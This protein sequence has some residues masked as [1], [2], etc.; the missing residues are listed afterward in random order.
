MLAFTA[1]LLALAQTPDTSAYLDPQARGL[2][3]RAR[4]A[5]DSLET[6]ILAYTAVVKQRIGLALRTPL[7]DRMLFRS[8]TAARV[9]WSRDE[10]AV[11][12][13]LGA[14]EF[15]PGSDFSDFNPAQV[16]F[17]DLFDPTMDRLYFGLRPM[18]QLVGSGDN[19]MWI[20]HPLVEGAEAKYRYQTG[21]TI[22]M[23]FPDGRQVRVVELR[24][25]PRRNATRLVAG[26]IWIEP[27]TGS[28]VKAAYRLP[29]TFDLERDTEVFSARDRE[30]M[31]N[32][33]GIFKPLQVDVTMISVEY[34]YWRL[35]HWLPRSLRMEGSARAGIA[36]APVEIEI[37]YDMQEV[38]EPGDSVTPAADVLRAWRMDTD[39]L[40]Q[41]RRN[42]K[43]IH[44]LVPKDAEQ[45]TNSRDL[46]PPIWESAPDFITEKELRKMY[47]GLARLPL[48][49]AL[50][51]DVTVRWGPQAQ[52][53]LRY[54]RVEAL[55]VGARVEA[56]RTAGTFWSTA[57]LGLADFAPNLEVGA[58]RET[59]WRTLSVTASHGLTA[60]DARALQLGSSVAA[61][62]LGR[63]EGDYYRTTGV[64][65]SVSPPTAQPQWYQ[66]TLFA[67]R[68]RSAARETD[69]SLPH[70]FDR[71]L[72]FRPNLQAD[73]A[74]LAGAEL[75]LRKWWGS[76][77]RQW[78]AGVE[79][80]LEGAD[81]D[82]RFARAALTARTA[83]PIADRWRGALE[84]AGGS[85]EGEVPAQ[86]QFFLGGAHTL[87][88]YGG[89]AAVGT[90]F[91][92][93]RTELAYT[94]SSAGLSLFSD[95]GWA[96][97][98]NTFDAD[99]AHVSAGVG[100]TILDGLIRI[101]L[102]RALRHT[103]GWRLELYLDAL[104]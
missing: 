59:M 65:V 78:Q 71:G 43:S 53:L 94:M 27:S 14:R 103:P 21:D 50:A 88:G 70:L 6:T 52:D 57:R 95:A 63:D 89:A 17:D 74:E 7:K 61:L 2:V 68:Q 8:E 77:P 76:D 80:N 55:S 73:A 18:P 66:F 30:D 64:R 32:V 23:G 87:R 92:R 84:A 3:A 62:L 42:G 19:E 56:Q 90:S 47:G 98:R 44:T 38:S 102:A 60:V 33:P 28:I 37:A 58:R 54:N 48:P 91:L 36:R 11:V 26:S 9:R 86:K 75:A 29:A 39:H 40:S 85:S 22:T 97:A 20:E 51:T 10:A 82:Y 35:K 46:P 31:K 99:N 24:V 72:D 96:G 12:R 5:R 4:A 101:D 69:W 41:R 45:L 67:E 13:M 49:P 104:L 1:L 34:S 93:T 83:F 15:H 25:L 16:S 100:A 81:G 79:L